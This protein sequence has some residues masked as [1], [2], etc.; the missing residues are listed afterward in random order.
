MKTP[1]RA[2]I[3]IAMI[4]GLLGPVAAAPALA[5]HHGPDR[6]D[7]RGDDHRGPQRH[8]WRE[9]QFSGGHHW[10]KGQ[11]LSRGDRRYV[12]NDWRARGLRAPPRGYQWVR[13]GDN[14]GD[15]LLVAVASGLI[16]SILNQ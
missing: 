15:F 4:A 8:E 6:H 2:L 5:Q 10:R 9:A 14:S 13:E 1:I 7:N 12:V 11:R 3:P 16:A